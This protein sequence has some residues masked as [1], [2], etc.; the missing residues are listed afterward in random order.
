MELG[1]WPVPGNGLHP[2]RGIADTGRV[3][4]QTVGLRFGMHSSAWR[5]CQREQ[6]V[7]S[8][9]HLAAPVVGFNT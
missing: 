8:Y 7:R 5:E 9:H 4:R 2:Q 6:A 1:A 3:C